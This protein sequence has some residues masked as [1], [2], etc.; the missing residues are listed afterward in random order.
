MSK[1]DILAIGHLNNDYILD[2]ADFPPVG[3]SATVKHLNTYD[4]GTAANVAVVASNLGVKTAFYTYVGHDF[5]NTPYF[6]RIKNMDYCLGILREV[7]DL[8]TST[9]FVLNDIDKNQKSYIYQGAATQFNTGEVP[10]EWIKQSKIIHLTT[11]APLYNVYSAH[12]AQLANKKVS[13]DPGQNL[14]EYN[15]ERLSQVLVN[16]DYLFGNEDEINSILQIADGDVE[17]LLNNWDIQF[18]VQTLGSK[19]SK[20]YYRTPLDFVD[21]ITADPVP[22][23]AVDPTG[24]GDSYKAGFLSAYLKGKTYKECLGFAS[25]VA[26][27]VVEKQGCQTNIPTLEQVLERAAENYGTFKNIGVKEW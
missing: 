5:I 3:G 7:P 14:R 24:A 2:V 12:E 18:M 6:N 1:Y 25:T 27:F 10:T 19:G 21:T 4:G 8:N 11:A 22:V 16:T 17:L 13:F 9:C 15:S 26:S 23:K 20:M